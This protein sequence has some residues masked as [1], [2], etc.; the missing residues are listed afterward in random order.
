MK[1]IL[2][3]LGCAALIAPL[4]LSPAIAMGSGKSDDMKKEEM[5]PKNDMKMDGIN[6]ANMQNNTSMEQKDM[7]GNMP[8]DQQKDKM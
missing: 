8:M 5:M 6:N 2:T 7:N 1:K 4:A 3:I